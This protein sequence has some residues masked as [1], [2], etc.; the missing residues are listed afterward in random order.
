MYT[1]FCKSFLSR[2]RTEEPRLL[3]MLGCG[4]DRVPISLQFLAMNAVGW[5]LILKRWSSEFCVVLIS[6]YISTDKGYWWE[7]VISAVLLKS[8][9]VSWLV[10]EVR[11]QNIYKSK[12]NSEFESKFT[13]WC[14]NDSLT[15]KTRDVCVEYICIFGI[16]FRL[17]KQ[18]WI[19]RMQYWDWP[20]CRSLQMF[21]T[22]WV[23]FMLVRVWS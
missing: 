17:L 6:I 22:F 18:L 19:S 3:V 14:K 2:W 8:S 11:E 4:Q 13:Y 15:V 12:Y 16:F 7:N 10:R 20:R 5:F 21:I 9:P 23:V 1:W